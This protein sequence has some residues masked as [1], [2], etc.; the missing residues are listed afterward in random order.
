[1]MLDKTAS[2][3]IEF[4]ANTTCILARRSSMV[5]GAKYNQDY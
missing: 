4:E 2:S 1:M 5:V 3:S